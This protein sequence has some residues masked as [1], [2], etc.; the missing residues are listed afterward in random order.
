[1]SSNIGGQLKAIQIAENINAYMTELTDIVREYAMFEYRIADL[2]LRLR[3]AMSDGE[4]IEHLEETIVPH[5]QLN[6]KRIMIWAKTY[7]QLTNKG[8]PLKIIIRHSL[9][10]WKEIAS[11][12]TPQN[13]E[14]ISA[15]LYEVDYRNK[16]NKKW[17]K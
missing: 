7:Q 3:V 14:Q 10:R 5:Q 16:I 1:M 9:V 4:I 2:V 6:A 8:I 12:V 11:C 17:R 13:A 15:T